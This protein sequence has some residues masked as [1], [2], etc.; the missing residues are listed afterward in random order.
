MPMKTVS[1]LRFAQSQSI[2]CQLWDLEDFVCPLSLPLSTVVTLP[3]CLSWLRK[4]E[5][6]LLPLL[7]VLF[8]R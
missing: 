5:H 3:P 2:T 1:G 4:R 7:G 8:P 6:L